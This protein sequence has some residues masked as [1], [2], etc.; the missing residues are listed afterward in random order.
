MRRE[1]IKSNSNNYL[2]LGPILPKQAHL[3]WLAL[4]IGGVNVHS[5]VKMKNLKSAVYMPARSF[6]ARL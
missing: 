3:I 2:L 6:I 1:E 5:H 4:V